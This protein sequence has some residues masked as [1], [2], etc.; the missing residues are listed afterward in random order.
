MVKPVE[1]K[2]FVTSIKN[3]LE[4][5]QLQQE[6]HL[7]RNQIFSKELKHPQ[8]FSEIITRSEAMRSI[9][10]YIESIAGSP[11]PILITGESG[12]GKELIARAIHRLS[13][14]EGDFVPV[15]YNCR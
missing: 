4:M 7:L 15:N 3:A 10:G 13:S 12:T 1:Q 5:R 14:R 11:K 6:V 2:Q 9:F 8:A